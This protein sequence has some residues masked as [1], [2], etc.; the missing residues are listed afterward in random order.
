MKLTTHFNI[1][2][3]SSRTDDTHPLPKCLHDTHRNNITFS[4]TGNAITANQVLKLTYSV[5]G[6]KVKDAAAW[7]GLS[8]R[9]QK[10]RSN[11]GEITNSV[12]TEHTRIE[13][14]AAVLLRLRRISYKISRQMNLRLHS[15]KSASKSF[16]ARPSDI[17]L[18]PSLVLGFKL[19]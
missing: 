15:M 3:S 10:V 13:K 19:K 12:R 18:H 11:G 6:S 2:L 1:V 17:L 14:L 5:A 8:H 4:F 9:G 16:S 7:S